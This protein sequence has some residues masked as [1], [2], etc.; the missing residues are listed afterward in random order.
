MTQAEFCA[1]KASKECEGVSLACLSDAP[2]CKAA[3]V[4][5]CEDFA[6]AQQTAPSSPALR[7]F[8]A[9]KAAACISKAAEV[10]KKSPITPADRS[11][12]D[13]VCARVFSGTRKDTDPDPSCNFDYECDS[14]QICDIWFKTCAKKRVVEASAGCNNPGEVCPSE[15]FCAAPT[16]HKCMPKLTAG[17]ACDDETNPCLD[18]LRCAAGVCAAPVVTAGKACSTNSDCVSTAP[19][20]DS[21]NGSICTPG[22][23]P[24]PGSNECVAAFGGVDTTGASG[25]ASGGGTGGAAGI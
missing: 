20:C 11:A 19:Y 14:P 24:S 2:A 25:G 5:A 9:D 12:L 1:Q 10:Y 13:E 3:R 21:Y 15:Q 17:M 8:R 6:M 23:I 22:F 4:Q 7:P 18:T 16:P